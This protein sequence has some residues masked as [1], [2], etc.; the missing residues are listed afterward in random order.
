MPF[1]ALLPMRGKSQACRKTS[2]WPSH[3]EKAFLPTDH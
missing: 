2:A 3:I 1:L